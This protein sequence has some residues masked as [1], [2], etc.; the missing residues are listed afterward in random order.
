MSPY[1]GELGLDVERCQVAMT[2][3]SA[4]SYFLPTTVVV[5]S[6]QLFS[7][8]PLI[9]LPRSC[10]PVR[11]GKPSRLTTPRGRD[12][13]EIEPATGVPRSCCA[14]L[15]LPSTPKHMAEKRQRDGRMGRRVLV[16][17]R[18]PCS[19]TR[20]FQGWGATA[21]LSESTND[22][23][24]AWVRETAH[25]ADWSPGRGRRACQAGMSASSVVL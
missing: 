2:G 5:V 21:K 17:I 24:S 6:V 12:T 4:A 16:R 15:S 11:C 23:T 9:R 20:S 25:N 13:P 1:Q 22:A 18:D 8:T 7:T 3:V 10:E 14:S 19:S